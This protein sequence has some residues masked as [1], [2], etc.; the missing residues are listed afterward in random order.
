VQTGDQLT[1]TLLTEIVKHGKFGDEKRVAVMV[2]NLGATTEMAS[3]N[4]STV[5][6][7]LTR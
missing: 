7:S 1:E 2:N 4:F 3:V 5:Q 6:V